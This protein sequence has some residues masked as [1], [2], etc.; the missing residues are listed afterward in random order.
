MDISM[1][2]E[3]VKSTLLP[4]VN[5]EVQRNVDLET[6]GN[7]Y[8]IAAAVMIVELVT[9]VMFI[10]TRGQFDGDDWTSLVSVLFCML[11][12]LASFVCAD[13]MRKR[14]C[15]SHA[16]SAAFMIACFLVLSGWAIFVAGRQYNRGE[17]LHTFYAVE[18]MM[19]CFIP[20]RPVYSAVLLTAI[21]ASL[22]A[23]LFTIDGA[24]GVNIF[25]YIVLVV[26]SIVGMIVRYH[27]QVRMAE[28]SIE[29]ERNNLLLEYVNR[30]DALTGLR[31]R[32]ALDEDAEETLHSPVAACMIDINYFKEF[33]DTYGHGVGDAV[34]KVTARLL[35]ELYPRCRCYR[36]GGDEFLVLGPEAGAYDKDTYVFTD[37]GIPNTE[38]VLSIGRAR[39][40]PVNHD[41]FFALIAEADANLYEVKSRT[42]V[43]RVPRI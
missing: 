32:L 26:V 41:E 33:N 16:T 14:G 8:H 15:A 25:N 12:C 27:S 18:L 35:K 3:S 31:N 43:H 2:L 7:I 23:L 5:V 6:I 4:S 36:Y 38:I 10:T 28:K 17:Q 11:V 37:P 29:L 1:T 40:Q 19:V 30:H 42:H 21:Y 20:L 39:G 9:L 13:R 34:L 22:Y 24:K